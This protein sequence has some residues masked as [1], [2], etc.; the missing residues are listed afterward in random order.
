M[1]TIDTVLD[2]A[3]AFERASGKAW[4]GDFARIYYRNLQEPPN[5]ETYFVSGVANMKTA[6]DNPNWRR[7][8]A[9]DVVER[10][11]RGLD[12][13][14]IDHA[15]TATDALESQFSASR[16]HAMTLLESLSAQHWSSSL[17]EITNSIR[18]L[19][20]RS[21]ADIRNEG[22]PS[23]GDTRPVIALV[24]GGDIVIPP[25]RPVLAKAR[26]IVNVFEAFEDLLEFVDE[27]ILHMSI[28]EASPTESDPG[29]RIFIGHGHSNEWLKLEKFLKDRLNLEVE[30]F[31]GKPPAGFT[32]KERLE[33]MLV[34][35]CFAFLVLT[36][37]DEIADAESEDEHEKTRIQA[38]MNVIHE[39]GLFQGRLGFDKA[40]ILLEEDCEEFSNIHGLVHIP[41]PKNNI[42]AAFEEIRR[43]LEDRGII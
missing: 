36:A 13:A 43:V 12:P 42:K 14:Q 17:A 1:Q 21:E 11:N 38:R 29:E 31:D 40:I 34:S 8:E 9:Q 7:Y 22:K 3:E 18:N 20:I 24:L 10:I 5:G 2:R 30:E 25:H 37:E 19:K 28:I 4:Y 27:A 6:S 32:V 26:W 39:A 23:V 41:F 33:Q 15:A 35:S 16:R